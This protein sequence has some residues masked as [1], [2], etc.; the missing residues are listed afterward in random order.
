MDRQFL[1]GFGL[2]DTQIDQILNKASNEIGNKVNEHEQAIQA[3]RQKYEAL[4][5]ELNTANDTIKNLQKSNKDNEEL[6]RQI[7]QYKA[8]IESVKAQ[9]EADRIDM[10]IKMALTNAGAINPL[11]V[12]PL[13]NRETIVVGKDGTIA[14]IDEQIRAIAENEANAYLFKQVEETSIP[15]P[16]RGG[17]APEGTY[18]APENPSFGGET[19]NI[20]ELMGKEFAQAKGENSDFARANSYYNNGY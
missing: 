19:L 20:G 5:N 7:N 9:A 1:K 3:E 4:Q 18:S 12:M 2:D 14:G 13:V 10:T 11:T 16:Q 6:Q 8:D 17:Y 15:E